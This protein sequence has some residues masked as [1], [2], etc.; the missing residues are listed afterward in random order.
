MRTLNVPVD[1]DAD[2][3]I[4][5]HMDALEDLYLDQCSITYDRDKRQI[6]LTPPRPTDE[7]TKGA[8]NE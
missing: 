3:V 5:V 7:K 4:H 6:V 1:V 8:N 2:C